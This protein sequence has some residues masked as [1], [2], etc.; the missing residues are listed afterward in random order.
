VFSGG[1]QYGFLVDD[2][3]CHCLRSCTD[4]DRC[5]KHLNENVSEMMWEEQLPK[6]FIAFEYLIGCDNAFVDE[7]FVNLCTLVEHLSIY[8]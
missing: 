3:F 2:P 4:S 5:M 1:R 7:E 8:K 6:L